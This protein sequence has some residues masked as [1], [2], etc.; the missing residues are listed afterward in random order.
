MGLNKAYVFFLGVAFCLGITYARSQDII[1]KLNQLKAANNLQE[2][3]YIRMDHTAANPQQHLP[4]LMATQKE[5]WRQ[6]KTP[7]EQLAWMLLLSNQGYYQ[8][9]AGDILSSINCYEDA[10]SFF[11]KHKLPDFDVV[12]YVLK[13]LSNNYTRLGDYER[14]IFIQQKAIGQL[15]PVSDAD[16]IAAIYSNMAIAYYDT[17]NY[18]QAENYIA[19]GNKLVKDAQV[20]FHLQNILGDILFEKQQYEQAAI[21]LQ[22]NI[23]TAK[24]IDEESAYWLMGSFTTLGKIN[25]KLG[26]LNEAEQNFNRALNLVNQYYPGGRLREKANLVAQQGIIER[27]RNQPQK[28]LLLFNQA[29]Q[30]L[31]INTNANQTR[32]GQI[33]GENRLVEIFQEKALAYRLMGQDEPALENL[34]YALLATDKVRKEFADNKTKE[35]L[36]QEGKE[37]AESTIELALKL[38]AK[39]RDQQYTHLILQIAEQTKARTLADKLQESNG[40]KSS[41]DDTDVN[42]RREIERAIVYNEKM[43]MTENNEAI[44]QKKIDALKFDLALLN[45]KNRQISVGSVASAASILSALPDNLHVLEFFVGERNAYVIEVKNKKVFQV[46]KTGNADSLKR[47]VNKLVNTYYRH[48]PDAML[49]APKA[50]YLASNTLYNTLFNQIALA[51]DERFCIVADDVLG[52]LSFDGLITDSKYNPAISQWPFLIK[53]ATA[54]Y[55]FSLN[56]LTANKANKTGTG[57][58]GLFITHQ[59]S[60]PVVAVEKEAAAI[61]QLVS[62]SYIYNDEVN[63]ASFFKAFENSAVL[64]IGTHAYLSGA[65]SEPTLDLGKDKLY[66]FELLAKQQKPALVVLSACRTGDGLLAKSEGIISLARGFSAIGTPATIAGLWNV[67][68]D[69]ASQITAGFYS[70]LVKGQTSGLALHGAKLEWLQTPKTTDALYLPYYWDSL[71]L[72]GADAPVKISSDDTHVLLFSAA[73]GMIVL[74]IVVIL[75]KMRSNRPPRLF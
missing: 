47:Q 35:R 73:Y 26:K 50:F 24:N 30:I 2:W 3:L 33:Y 32:P 9:Q 15:N 40:G 71:I 38:F 61:K 31:R 23:A 44:Y 21:V 53:R 59:N 5:T 19:K 18:T 1:P 37:L 67:N 49:N 16:K 36:Q 7:D 34:R 74:L 20:R 28:A 51:K 52:Y 68:D 62:G 4:F 41:A 11:Y 63:P 65:S 6:P 14:A 42:K 25:I 69:A 43:M 66:L 46:I 60:K 55:A 22:S 72:M 17:G 54:T 56:T 29:L 48:G 12:E 45:K 58:S 64:H 27:V 75:R 10:Y 57:F 13:P 70:F 39:A 8:L